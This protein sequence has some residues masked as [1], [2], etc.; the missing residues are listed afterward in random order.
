MN[1]GVPTTSGLLSRQRASPYPRP[2]I[3]ASNA[4]DAPG[5]AKQRP[6]PL[7]THSR[8]GSASTTLTV[9]LP[10]EQVPV[11]DLVQLARKAFSLKDFV[12]AFHYLTRALTIAP[13]DIN[14]LDSRAASLEKIGRLEDAL[15]DAKS[16]IRNQPQNPKGYLR[17]GKVL[18]LQQNF[19]SS[20]K[21]F[22]AG[23]ERCDKENKEYEALREAR[24]LDPMER[25]PFEL[26]MVVF[27]SLSF[28]ERVRCLIISK[29]WMAYLGSVRHFWHSIDLAKRIPSPVRTPRHALYLPAQPDQEPN[30]KV[31]NKT[32]LSLV[33]YTPPKVLRL[34]CAQQVSSG[35]LTQLSKMKRTTALETISL[36][37]NTKIF[38]QELSLFWS[39]TPNLRCVDLHGCP[40]VT[41][42]VVNSLLDRC[43]LLEELDISECRTTEACVMI[44]YAVPLR[45]MRKLVFGRWEAPFAKEGIDAL[46]S[47][48]PNLVTLDIRTMRPR[49]IEAL[50]S[51]GRL[52]HLRHLF[53][54]SV[55]TTGDQTTTFVL[56]RWLEGIPDLESLQ[57]NACKGVSDSMIQLIAAG[58]TE[59]ESGRRG[60]SHSL[61]MLDLSSS[62]Y[63]TSEGLSFL[64]THP[65]PSLHTLLLNKCGRVS[66][67]GLRDVVA[68]SGG[69][70]CRLECAGYRSVSDKL[71]MDIRDH[72]PKIEVL[73]LA[74][75]GQVTGIGL[76]ALVNERGRGLERV[77]LDDCTTVGV[78]AVERART[79]L[80]DS[81]RISHRF[82]RTH[83]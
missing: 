47:K 75:S 15:A 37:T 83:R 58:H 41:D 18:R 62:P 28:T 70:L 73:Q 9:V 72:C 56:Q 10:K 30:N 7:I 11:N 52:V 54:D 48:F 1:A 4:P 2:A 50:E 12:T 19:K 77:C 5:H 17:A 21:I 6:R 59:T 74:N 3:L 8:S 39:T 42:T 53:T 44:N 22:I 63:L 79:V 78:D 26:V 33:K 61:R 34:G 69:E 43:P 76:M 81:G 13:K 23:A 80:G 57:M 24:V 60:W 45:S 67:Q 64:R 68:S 82:H 55:E 32:V 35:L 65:L 27:D 16:M 49:G 31:T 25:L 66:E 14:L 29:K 38:E 46:V 51:L 40:G 36:R 20:A 71:L